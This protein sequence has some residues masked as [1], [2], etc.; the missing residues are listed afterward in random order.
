LKFIIYENIFETNNFH[1]VVSIP[2]EGY[3]RKAQDQKSTFV[4]IHFTRKTIQE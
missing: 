3:D 1:S 2:G 4:L